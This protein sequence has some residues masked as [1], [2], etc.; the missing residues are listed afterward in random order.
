MNA[1]SRPSPEPPGLPP[2]A[3]P[4]G[5]FL[6]QLFLVPGL[7]VALVV[8]LLLGI[9]WLINGPRSPESYLKKLDDSNPDIRWRAAAD[10]AQVLPRDPGLASDAGFAL[11]LAD[12]LEKS[13]AAHAPA[14]KAWAEKAPAATKQE[15]EVEKKRLEPERTYIL[16][17]ASSLGHFKVPAGVFVLKEMAT[18]EGGMEPRDLARQRRLAAWHLANLGESVTTFDRLSPLQQAVILQQL[19]AAA[20]QGSRPEWA[21]A[22]GEYLRRRQ[23]GKPDALGVDKVLIRCSEDDNPFLREVAAFAM[24]FWTGTAKEEEAMEEALVRLSYDDGRGEEKL[25]DLLEEEAAE[26]AGVTTQELARKNDTR[27]LVKKKGYKVQATATIALARHGS[28]RTRIDLLEEMLDPDQ[29]RRVFLTQ[30]KQT[31]EEKPDEAVVTQ[32]VLN[33]LKAVARLHQRRP[34][35]QL[36]G[37]HAAVTKLLDSENAAIQKEAKE[38]QNALNMSK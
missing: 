8:L 36:K 15:A 6:I 33:A 32:T 16:Y 28:T 4:T 22:C 23:E 27:T 18:Q 3:P 11:Q 34:E 37:C 12:R 31:G 9:Y 5:K 30:N 17:L 21:R 24:N 38:T 7:I 1:T 14:E 26:E 35:L 29:L 10:L 19:D 13:R 25:N 20:E 2:V